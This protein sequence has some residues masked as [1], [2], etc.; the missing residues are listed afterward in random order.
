MA[1]VARGDQLRRLRSARHETQQDVA[2][3]VGVSLRAYQAWEA[4][5]TIK[6]VNAKRLGEHFA[7]NPESLTAREDE[8]ETPDA[9]GAL[10]DTGTIAEVLDRLGAIESRLATQAARNEEMRIALDQLVARQELGANGGSQSPR[11]RRR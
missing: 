11:A 6:W 3:E 5:G 9:I 2:D 10:N 8:D 7:I 1:D 4:G